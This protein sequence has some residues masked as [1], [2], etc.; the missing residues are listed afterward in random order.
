MSADDVDVELREQQLSRS[1][2]LL[3]TD[4]MNKLQCARVALVGAGA[5]IAHTAL[6]LARSGVRHIVLVAPTSA[7]AVRQSL[8][9]NP[10]V[11]RADVAAALPLVDCVRQRV[12]EIWSADSQR[13]PTTVEHVES[14]AQLFAPNR[15]PVQ[16]VA[17]VADDNDDEGDNGASVAD[18][19]RLCAASHAVPTIVVV[20][21]SWRGAADVTRLKVSS[22]ADSAIDDW[23]AR[24]IRRLLLLRDVRSNVALVHASQSVKP[25]TA[26]HDDDDDDAAAAAAAAIATTLGSVVASQVI[27]CVAGTLPVEWCGGDAT[28]AAAFA[29]EA[30]ERFGRQHKG[31]ECARLTAQLVEYVIDCMWNQRSAW[32]RRGGKSLSLAVIERGAP[33]DQFNV[34]PLLDDELAAFNAGGLAAL[35]PEQRTFVQAVFAHERRLQRALGRTE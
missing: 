33:V 3:G 24:R 19:V 10:C 8:L 13:S 16:A 11:R 22:V 30:R 34:L 20:G 28:A 32:S 7:R 18:D 26:V 35:T 27:A 2:A 1:Y 5:V 25:T 15:V 31:V 9:L 14:L 6:H 12:Q 29:R 4:A 21:A 17:M 23:A